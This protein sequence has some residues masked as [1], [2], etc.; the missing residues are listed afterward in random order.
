MSFRDAGSDSTI[1]VVWRQKVCASV[2][3][4]IYVRPRERDEKCGPNPNGSLAASERQR[5][6]MVLCVMYID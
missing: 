4:G 1:E 3:I 6:C 5:Q 2:H